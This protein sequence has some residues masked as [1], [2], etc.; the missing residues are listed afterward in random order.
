MVWDFQLHQ[1][2]DAMIEAPMQANRDGEGLEN[3]CQVL[4]AG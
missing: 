3:T 4:I 2:A 1:V